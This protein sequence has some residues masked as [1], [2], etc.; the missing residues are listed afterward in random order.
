MQRSPQPQARRG[1]AGPPPHGA[2]LAAAVAEAV[3]GAF[4]ALP[5]TGKP[6]PHEYTVL[7]G[8]ERG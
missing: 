7:A 8:A 6:Q 5:K 3:Q 4:A 2:G 1:M